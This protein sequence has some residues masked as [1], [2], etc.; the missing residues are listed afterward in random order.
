M[1]RSRTTFKAVSIRPMRPRSSA[2]TISAR[3]P[4]AA[5]WWRDWCIRLP[6][7]LR[8]RLH[9]ACLQLR[10]RHRGW[11]CHGLLGRCVRS[12]IPT[13]H[14]D[15]QQRAVPVRH[16][17][18][19]QRHRARLLDAAG[20]HGVLRLDRDDLVHAHVH[21]QGE[22]ARV[23]PCRARARRFRVHAWLRATSSPTRSR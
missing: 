22:V 3:T 13:P 19:G 11:L 4:P 16:H 12:A 6:S 8:V 9:P 7:S 2:D 14:R 15:S 5:T 1:T 23:R 18:R 17:D 20:G 21:L 10:D